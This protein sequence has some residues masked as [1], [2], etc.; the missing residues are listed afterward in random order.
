MT[1]PLHGNDGTAV[2]LHAATVASRDAVRND[3]TDPGADAAVADAD[4]VPTKKVKFGSLLK[5]MN[6]EVTKPRR[7]T[8][9]DEL[10]EYASS[11]SLKPSAVAAAA[12]IDPEQFWLQGV[13]NRYPTLGQLALD[14]ISVPASES[15]AERVFSYCGILATGPNNRTAKNLHRSAFLRLNSS[16]PSQNS[17]LKN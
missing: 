7:H 16:R 10:S 3:T 15:C 6:I 2:G 5:I 14:F 17:L 12:S 11:L 4:A 13:S 1:V 9:A 8:V